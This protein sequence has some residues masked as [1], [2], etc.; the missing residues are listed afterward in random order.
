MTVSFRGSTVMESRLGIPSLRLGFGQA[1]RSTI[2]FGCARFYPHF[3]PR[4]KLGKKN[5]QPIGKLTGIPEKIPANHQ[6]VITRPMI[7]NERVTT[8]SIM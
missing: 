8:L 7:Q 4:V 2:T 1:L 3:T 5:E 6:R